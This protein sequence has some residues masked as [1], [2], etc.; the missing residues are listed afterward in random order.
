ML[1]ETKAFNSG[2][3]TTEM[4]SMEEIKTIQRRKYLLLYRNILSLVSFITVLVL[5]LT[6]ASDCHLFSIICVILFLLSLGVHN[7]SGLICYLF[8][9][10]VT[11]M[12][13]SLIVTVRMV[14]YD[15]VKNQY[16]H[17][18]IIRI[19][20]FTSPISADWSIVSQDI[21]ATLLESYIEL[22][23]ALL[24]YMI[25]L[26]LCTI[27]R[28]TRNECQHTLGNVAGTYM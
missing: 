3:P 25:T 23:C 6:I 22:L 19:L 17:N 26:S 18:D 21:I 15:Y 12:L 28:V 8:I 1:E 13:Y 5:L 24:L 7:Y 9:V 2:L 11:Q 14:V 16:N 10:C 20:G 27:N 4:T